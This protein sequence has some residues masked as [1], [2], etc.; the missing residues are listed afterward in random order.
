MGQRSRKRGR[1]GQA[2]SE[3]RDQAAREDLEP[4]TPGE[5]PTVVTVGAFVALAYAAANAIAFAAGVKVRGQEQ[6]ASAVI[7]FSAIMATAAWGMWNV[8]YWAVLGFQ[9]LLALIMITLAL[10]LL[11]ATTIAAAVFCLAVGIPSGIL[12]WKLVR[13]MA[14][15]QMPDRP[16]PR[17]PSV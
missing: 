12:F 17:G 14:R 13:A 10:S 5:R 11:V 6:Q 4:L 7:I 1:T 9:M 15:I 8:K 3:V 2:R 16:Q